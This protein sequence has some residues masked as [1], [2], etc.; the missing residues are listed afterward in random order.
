LLR[1]V[2]RNRSRLAALKKRYE[3]A[4]YLSEQSQVL[5]REKEKLVHLMYHMFDGLQNLYA[6]KNVL[7]CGLPVTGFKAELPNCSL[8]KTLC[9]SNKMLEKMCEP[10]QEH[11]PLYSKIGQEVAAIQSSVTSIAEAQHRFYIPPHTQSTR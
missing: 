1:E 8:E 3:E 7:D 11:G 5:I 4:T 10:I 2:D 9:E 6:L